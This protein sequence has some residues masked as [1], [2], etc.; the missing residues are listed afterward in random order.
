[1]FSATGMIDVR[2]FAV[3]T[4]F[5]DSGN[6]EVADVEQVDEA[7]WDINLAEVVQVNALAVP[8]DRELT[9][10]VMQNVVRLLLSFLEDEPESPLT[11]RQGGFRASSAHVK[12]FVS[13]S[14]GLGMLTATAE[15]H[16][17]W[18][19]NR[20]IYITSTCCRQR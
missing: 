6:L 8:A 11:L 10:R 18:K 13:E 1:M 4:Y 17:R 3:A 2:R 16:H 9:Y 14:F 20:P 15:H 5:G 19:V 7:T 12:R